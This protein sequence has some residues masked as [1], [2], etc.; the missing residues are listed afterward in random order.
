MTPEDLGGARRRFCL[1]DGLHVYS[2][3]RATNNKRRAAI[4][5]VFSFLFVLTST[6]H[7]DRSKE[8]D[9]TRIVPGDVRFYVEFRGLSAVRVQFKR[10]GIWDTAMDLRADEAR[11]ATATQPWQQRTHEL[12]GLEPEE[13]IG[14][15]LGYRS[16]LIAA[17][18]AQWDNGV[19]LAE[20]ARDDQLERMLEAWD[21]TETTSEGAVKR[22]RLSG[23]LMLASLGRVIAIAPA[24]DPDGLWGR[25]VLLMAGQKGPTLA[26]R[27]DFAAL[28]TRLSPDPQGLLYAVWKRD[29][30]T[31]FAGCR[32]LVLGIWME[33]ENILCELHGHRAKPKLGDKPI[34]PA[35]LSGIPASAIAAWCGSLDF[36]SL[37]NQDLES[38][39]LDEQSLM[40]TFLSAIGWGAT[41]QQTLIDTLG[42]ECRILFGNDPAAAKVEL[43]VPSAAIVVQAGKAPDMVANL[44]VILDIIAQGMAAFAAAPGERI[45]PT[46][47]IVKN[48]EGVELHGI[49]IGSIL[50]RRLEMPFLRHT[51]LA[52]GQMDGRLLVSSSRAF[53]EELVRATL[54]K[55]DRLDQ[56]IIV[57]TD[58]H[59]RRDDGPIVEFL[60]IRGTELSKMLTSWAEYVETRHPQATK[61]EWWR[62]WADQKVEARSRLDVA[63]SEDPAV[64]GK[65]TVVEVGEFS[66]AFNMLYPGD[67]VIAAAGAPLEGAQPARQV[68]DRYRD[69]GESD[70]FPLTVLREGKQMVLEIKVSPAT[71]LEPGILDPVRAVRQFASLA[72]RAE[73][74]TYIRR[75]TRPERLDA[76][77]RIK[78]DISSN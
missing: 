34:D 27:A 22:Y 4:P 18:P 10:L 70:V 23:G 68:A 66:P 2:P 32:R 13:A 50:A 61:P 25:T 69:R 37:R 41:N 73:N 14:E 67:I 62:R 16:A 77:I 74:V 15:L 42:P 71:R 72:Q 44:D 30:P 76:S 52:W 21:A 6:V 49:R 35:D 53:A 59:S 19:L 55:A 8:A 24:G 33:A 75:L 48:C 64:P 1:E 20:L 57:E 45:S 39:R 17:E 31:A 40:D 58:H 54:G 9:W 5:A 36:R 26:G 78:W 63:L 56:D 3:I 46:P 60:L 65:A 28:R 12:L 43:K 38:R 7:A 11:R 29:D 47:V 51:E